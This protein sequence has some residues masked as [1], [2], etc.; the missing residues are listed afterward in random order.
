MTNIKS[1]PYILINLG[2][3]GPAPLPERLEVI[4]KL[5]INIECYSVYLRLDNW[6]W[7][8]TIRFKI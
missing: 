6:C 1:M 7:I 8:I 2:V 3:P 4:H 5:S